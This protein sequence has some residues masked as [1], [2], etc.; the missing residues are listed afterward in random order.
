MRFCVISALGVLGSIGCV[1]LTP[2]DDVLAKVP[3]EEFL[4]IEGRF[5][6]VE[7]MGSGRPLVLLHGFGGSTYSFRLV[8]SELAESFDV[9]SIDLNG[10]GYTE[11]PP[12][13]ELYTPYG[14]A[15]Q[16]VAILDAL[17]IGRASLLGHSYGAEIALLTA[18][19]RPELVESLI[20]VDGSAPR[21]GFMTIPEEFRGLYSLLARVFLV[22][23][24]TMRSFLKQSVR[25]PAI[26]TDE[27]VRGYADRIL[28]E[29]LD[30]AVEGLLAGASG[31]PIEI[32]VSIVDQPTLIVWGEHDRVVPIA[33]GEELAADLPNARLVRF[34][35]SGHLPMEEEP[36]RFAR[37]VTEFL[38]GV[39]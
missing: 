30:R 9:I 38:T 12:G 15:A 1:P 18:A 24:G 13:T 36:D 14:Q 25:D 39:E 29:G 33:V 22:N 3:A 37:V 16:V 27:L 23:E 17:G 11:R 20:L 7:R 4:V 5:V 28:I 35:Q 19:T 2:Y 34:E 26:V 21:G 6:H 8:V 10:F 32:D 31:D